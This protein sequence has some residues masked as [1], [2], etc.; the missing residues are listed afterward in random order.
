VLEY[1]PGDGDRLSLEQREIGD[2]AH[3]GLVVLQ[4]HHLLSRAMQRF[5]VLHSPLQHSTHCCSYMN[6]SFLS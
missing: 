6:K 1:R 2:A 4:E 3:S 5:P